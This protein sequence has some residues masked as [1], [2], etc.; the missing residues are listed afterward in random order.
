MGVIKLSIVRWP[1]CELRFNVLPLNS[2]IGYTSHFYINMP[3]KNITRNEG[4][5]NTLVWLEKI[6]AITINVFTIN[7]LF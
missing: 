2:A 1:T 5:C 4:N 3:D 7:V 6:V